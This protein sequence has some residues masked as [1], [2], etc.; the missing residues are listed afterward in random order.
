MGIP[1]KNLC[2]ISS[3]DHLSALVFHNQKENQI[4]TQT[5]ELPQIKKCTNY[6]SSSWSSFPFL[7]KK[8][9]L[10]KIC[11]KL[12]WTQRVNQEP[13]LWVEA[14]PPPSSA[15]QSMSSPSLS[16]S[17]SLTLPSSVHSPPE[18]M[19]WILFPTFSTTLEE[20]CKLFV[21]EVADQEGHL[22][23]IDT[24]GLLRCWAQ[25]WMPSPT[26]R[27]STKTKRLDRTFPVCPVSGTSSGRRYNRDTRIRNRNYAPCWRGRRYLNTNQ[28]YRD[29]PRAVSSTVAY[30]ETAR[31]QRLPLFYIGNHLI[32]Q[33]KKYFV[34]QI[35]MT[36]EVVKNISFCFLMI[37]P[38]CFGMT[39]R[40]YT[41]GVGNF[42]SA[43]SRCKNSKFK[44]FN[45]FDH[46]GP[47]LH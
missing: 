15:M 35:D 9:S 41:L 6:W 21:R 32:F 25:S 11:Q 10:P 43:K 29:V 45:Q 18:A 38:G 3:S 40:V 14:I 44:H 7:P 36:W 4:K 47:D 31:N 28:T 1:S 19:I 22:I 34:R 27:R 23:N 5:T 20:V 16:L 39:P 24:R 42:S 30:L 2:V 8:Q 17:F 33:V 37:H 13:Y 12:N 26:P 46:F